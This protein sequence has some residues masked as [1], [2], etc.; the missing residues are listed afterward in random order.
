MIAAARSLAASVYVCGVSIEQARR[1]GLQLAERG[2]STTIGYWNLRNEAPDCVLTEYLRTTEAIENLPCGGYISIKAPALQ[3]DI[4][5]IGVLLARTARREI[6]LHFD[7]HGPEHA[8]RTLGLAMA[9]RAANCIGIT[10]PS[11]WKRSNRD[12]ET[13]AAAGLKIRL[14]KGQWP[15]PGQRLKDAR[16]R[17]LRMAEA[18]KGC[19]NPVAIATHD[20]LLARTALLGLLEAG[21]PCELELLFG[22]PMKRSIQLA[23]DLRVPVRVYVPYGHAFLPYRLRDSLV[24]PKILAWFVKD[25]WRGLRWSRVRPA[26]DYPT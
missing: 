1:T 15:E 6:L 16:A 8:G 4:D 20:A 17:F 22:L 19:R 12:L 2:I 7:S 14:V 9:A 10:I 21:T 11:R 25:V 23:S 24:R 18:L 3:F 26:G 13:A 5:R